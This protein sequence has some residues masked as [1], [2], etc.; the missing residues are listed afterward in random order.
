M[1]IIKSCFASRRLLGLLWLMSMAPVS[2]A[3][4]L[5]VIVSTKNPINALRVNQVADVFLAQ[6]GSFP[7]GGE[8]VAVDQHI[9]SAIR[10]EFYSKVT[11]L[12]E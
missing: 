12:M 2:A 5:V 6:I 4:E 9:G 10:D 8:A 1:T 3:G 7:E 11:G